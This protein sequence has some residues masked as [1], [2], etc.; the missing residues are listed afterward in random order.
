MAARTFLDTHVVVWTYAGRKSL[1]SRL[2]RRA[3]EREAV[4]VSPM[5]LLE[6]DFLREIGR[7]HGS[8][9]NMVKDLE[10]RIGLRIS[11]TAFRDVVSAASAQSWTLDPFD[12]IIVGDASIH[13]DALVTKDGPILDHYPHA[14]W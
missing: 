4:F 2:A 10:T 12:R 8:G 7:V 11:D 5:V 1:L 6:I 9:G 14:L 13:G 3:L